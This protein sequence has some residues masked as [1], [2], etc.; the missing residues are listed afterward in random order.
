MASIQNIRDGIATRLNTISGLYTYADIPDSIMVP[1]AVVG[2]PTNITYDFSFRSP[3]CRMSIPVRVYAG[4][5]LELEAQARLDGL[6]SADGASSVRAAIDGDITLSGAAQTA[7]L[8]SAQAY[9]AYDLQ[10]VSYLGVEM[11]LEVIA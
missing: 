2:M 8:V 11:T 3:V 6:V 4:P 5:T 7:R 9:G 10:G 1:C